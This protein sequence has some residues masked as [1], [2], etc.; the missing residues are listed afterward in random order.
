MRNLF[1]CCITLLFTLNLEAQHIEPCGTPPIKSEWLKNYQANPDA[2]AKGGDTTLYVPVTVHVVGTDAGTGY[3]GMDD[4]FKTFCQLNV[5]FES[6]GI[7]FHI[8]GN[9]NYINN[10]E[11]YEHEDFVVGYTM[12]EENNIPGTFNCY[13]SEGAAGAGGY[14][15]PV[16]DAVV[17]AKGN[18]DL[19][20]WHTWGHEAGHYFTLNHTF[21]GWEGID[22]SLNEPTPEYVD[23]WGVPRLVERMDGSNCMNAADGFCDTPPDYLSS[24]FFC[25]SLGFSLQ[26]QKDPDSIFFRSDGGNYMSYA[27][28]ICNSYFSQEQQS[29]MRANL[30]NERQDLLTNQNVIDIPVADTVLLLAPLESEAVT[31]APVLQWTSVEHA[32]RYY[33][34]INRVSSFSPPLLV[35]EGIV[36]DTAAYITGLENNRNYY[37]RVRP[38]NSTYP[39]EGEYTTG[40]F[41]TG[42]G[43]FVDLQ[44]AEVLDGLT[45]YPNIL[46]AGEKARLQVNLNAP[47][48]MQIHLIDV[49]GRQVSTLFEGKANGDFWQDIETPSLSSGLYW[50]AIEANG[51]WA[52]RKLIILNE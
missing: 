16:S 42:E 13:I 30:V 52:Q 46:P 49:N 36:T 25:D 4:I 19:E 17:L 33:Y 12:M 8:E 23:G 51:V 9:F 35:D 6:V 7:K 29:A 44:N 31:E 1:L 43:V 2:Y 38:F 40:V 27:N 26:L 24:T 41:M 10:T 50:V 39:C 3:Y 37:W 15:S 5:D 11:W 21:F 28:G 45:L 34:E 18:L 48:D 20:T 22:Y 47:V 14:Y 32:N